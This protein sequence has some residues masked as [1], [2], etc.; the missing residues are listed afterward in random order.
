LAGSDLIK[1]RVWAGEMGHEHGS[2]VSLQRL[3]AAARARE[4]GLNPWAALNLLDEAV[5]AFPDSALSHRER[6]R[7]QL[8]LAA[9]L[10]ERE[11]TR[12]ARRDFIAALRCPDS[13]SRDWQGLALALVAE[14]R[15]EKLDRCVDGLL[16]DSMDLSPAR[17]LLAA[18]GRVAQG[19]SADAENL[20]R[21][22]MAQ[23]D[24]ATRSVFIRA[25]LTENQNDKFWI[26]QLAVERGATLR[27]QLWW[28]RVVQ[29]EVLFGSSKQAGW[30]TAPGRLMLR[31][32]RPDATLYDMQCSSGNCI[33]LETVVQRLSLNHIRRA[34]ET[35]IK[36]R[37][38]SLPLW[39][40]V[41]EF[42]G[43]RIPFFLQQGG[44]FST[45]HASGR[46]GIREEELAARLPVI[47]TPSRA[48]HGFDLAVDYAAFRTADQHINTQVSLAVRRGRH[49]K[50]TATMGTPAAVA[51]TDLPDSFRATLSVL[52]SNGHR[53][54]RVVRVLDSRYQRK[55]LL[56]PFGQIGDESVV[57]QLSVDLVPALYTTRLEV[58]DL[59]TGAYRASDRS[60]ELKLPAR[61]FGIS[62]IQLCDFFA[63]LPERGSVPDDFVRYAHVLIPHP[64]GRAYPGQSQLYVYF[65][66]YGVRTDSA[67]RVRLDTIYELFARNAF[68]PFDAGRPRGGY[69]ENPPLWR[70]EFEDE[71]S[72]KSPGGV[73][74][75]GTRLPLDDFP[76]GRYVLA[77]TV[78]DKLA[79]D[80]ARSFLEFRR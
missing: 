61:D 52:D 10:M 23:L 51:A 74:V 73:V 24:P 37:N 1:H 7:I 69:A 19:R 38:P 35:E 6:G 40:W 80:E 70:T 22:A 55:N 44:Y 78:N 30:D 4:L 15:M 58:E 31:Y 41:Y 25:G 12:A 9:R 77:V 3:L 66:V 34:V 36:E 13:D 32:G 8:S 43:L 79:R 50:R 48:D 46:S 21:R 76:P 64:E 33:D 17:L 26:E 20:F 5:R 47:L 29:T 42:A 60:F 75:K 53:L 72:G 62:E 56:A 65:E 68:Q 16:Q 49:A 28:L 45:W 11:R 54:D 2:D 57:V 39:I 67:G 63:E 18:A 59:V 27:S 71:S 14:G